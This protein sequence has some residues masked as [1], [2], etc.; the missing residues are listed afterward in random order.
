MFLNQPPLPWLIR[1]PRR[2]HRQWKVLVSLV[3]RESLREEPSLIKVNHP[4]FA[5]CRY[6]IFSVWRWH[7][8]FARKCLSWLPFLKII[9]HQKYLLKQSITTAGVILCSVFHTGWIIFFIWCK[10][11]IIHISTQSFVV[12]LHRITYSGS[13]LTLV[14]ASLRRQRDPCPTCWCCVETTA[15][16]RPAA[17]EA[18]R[19]QKSIRLWCS[20]VRP[21]KEKVHCLMLLKEAEEIL[22]G[23]DQWSR[24]SYT[25]SCRPM[26]SV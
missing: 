19:S 26:K 10:V 8:K 13:P 15:C 20:S 17:T 1:H 7:W 4:V 6:C 25:L 21:S 3:E 14:F 12:L 5:C 18:P 2:S 9:K 22:F 11:W 16:Q 23:R 24:C